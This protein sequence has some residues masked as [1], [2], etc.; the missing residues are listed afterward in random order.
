[1]RRMKIAVMLMSLLCTAA[2]CT[3][4]T[5]KELTKYSNMAVDAG[6]DTVLTYTEFGYDVEAM[7]K[8]FE[9]CEEMFSSFSDQF[10]IYNS[11]EGLNNL[12]TIND[13][14]GVQPVKVS[15]D[16][17]EMLKDAKLFYDLSDG[18]FDVTIGSLLKVWHNYREAGMA[19]NTEGKEAAVPSE[20]EL[21]EAAAYCGWDKIIIDEENQTV[22]I[23][24]PH[25]SLDVGG[26]AKGFAAEK[27]GQ[28]IESAA[29]S[30]ANINA[31]GNI[32]TVHSKADGTPWNIGIQDPDSGTYAV[33]VSMDGSLSFVTSGDYERYYTGSDGK[34]YHHIIDPATMYPADFYRSVSIVTEDSAAADALSTTLFCLSIED[35]KKVL[36]AYTE[37]SGKAADA[38]WLMEP[39][40]AQGKTEKA[41]SL[42]YAYTA[43][44]EGKIMH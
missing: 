1:M 18:A 29:E 2:G 31:G 28:K 39:D 5:K 17:I 8:N 10:D 19:A 24:D 34:R 7:R 9:T 20:A 4:E 38:V 33:I 23:T 37:H 13:N 42:V 32:R 30:Y 16:I 41:G 21:K 3:Q 15:A 22:F 26:I 44:L 35:G 6:F 14:A 25:V 40:K 36:A 27:I 12:K 43:G 11:F